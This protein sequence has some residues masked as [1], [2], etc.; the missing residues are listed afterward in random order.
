MFGS[1]KGAAFVARHVEEFAMGMH[2][3]SQVPVAK[4][5]DPAF[6]LTS[7]RPDRGQIVPVVY[8]ALAM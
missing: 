1:C 5:P 4:Q 2:V 6:S 8:R 3:K 7:L